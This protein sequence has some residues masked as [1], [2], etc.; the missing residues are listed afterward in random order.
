V[1]E[2]EGVKRALLTVAQALT[3]TVEVTRWGEGVVHPV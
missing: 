3:V 2:G 1:E